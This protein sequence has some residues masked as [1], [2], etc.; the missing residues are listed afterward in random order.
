MRGLVVAA[1]GA[2]VL[3]GCRIDDV[4]Y[5]NPDGDG[6][7]DAVDAVD[8]I[9]ATPGTGTILAAPTDLT[10]QEGSATAAG[11]R[12]SM[13][14]SAAVTVSV[15]AGG[16]ASGLAFTP[17]SLEFTPANWS[18]EQ[19]IFIDAVED[20][21]ASDSRKVI[22]FS[23]P[24][25]AAAMVPISITDNDVLALFV[26]PPA[27]DVTEGRTGMLQI[28]LTAAPA[29]MTTVTLSSSAPGVATVAPPS[30]TFT[31]ANWS[32][33]QSATVTGVDDPD[34]AS[35]TAVV[36]VAAPGMNSA[37][38]TV[39]VADDDVLAIVPST[40]TL[41][42]R[43]G[44]TSMGFSVALTQPPP[45]PMTVQ[46]TSSDPAVT[47]S[48]STLTFTTATAQP[49][50]INGVP[51]PDYADEAV[52]VTLRGSLPNVEDRLVAVAVTDVDIPA[53]V[54]SATSL[55]ATERGAPVTLDVHLAYQPVASAVVVLATLGSTRISLDRTQLTFTAGNY[56]T[57]QRVTITPLT[58]NDLAINNVAITLS[59]P[60]APSNVGV[61]VSIADADRQ[62][63]VATPTSLNVDEGAQ[64]TFTVNLGFVPSGSVSVAVAAGDS[65]LQ[66]MPSS[67]PFDATTWS[68]PRTVTVTASTDV[69]T[70]DLL[71]MATLSGAAAPQPTVVP[72]RIID[73]SVT[74]LA[75][76]P[77]MRTVAEGGTTTFV[78]T[79]T[80]QPSAPINGTVM[81]SDATIATV[82]RSTFVLDGANWNTGITVVVTGVPDANITDDT[83]TITFATG[84]A[85][86]STTVHVIDDDVLQVVL[87]TTDVRVP[88]T[89]SATVNVT[90]SAAPVANT[91]VTVAAPAGI[92]ASTASLAF[93]ATDWNSPHPVV[94]TAERDDDVI[95]DAKVVTFTPS[96]TGVA[97][98]A[99]VT[100]TVDFTIITGFPVPVADARARAVPSLHAW[101]APNVDHDGPVALPA[102]V[103][104]DK[105]YAVSEVTSTE[106]VQVGLYTPDG[107]GEPNVRV[108]DSASRVLAPGLNTYTFI[109]LELCARAPA[110][111]LAVR[112]SANAMLGHQ[113]LGA[114]IAHCTRN[115]GGGGIPTSFQGGNISCN[116]DAQPVAVW[117][118]VHAKTACNCTP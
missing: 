81:T 85:T 113:Q 73:R 48:P 51:D 97:A 102:C 69:D 12:L 47:V 109:G 18:A 110:V 77:S 21:D 24:G 60:D 82:N 74:E 57:D 86:R 75:V 49:V 35:G 88:E 105:M 37:E 79:L 72:V 32:T 8:A 89:G 5:L 6:G 62:T 87:S 64:T 111:F 10:V 13:P 56:A 17:S 59:T 116:T 14:P 42:I 29:T 20:D 107:N 71:T 106:T 22:V 43:E 34:I 38:V 90:L 76:S 78:V 45:S 93:N 67:L 1:I 46:L 92:M 99:T 58:D 100:E 94:L 104:I 115:G 95:L 41:T 9:D 31:S 70:L 114:P 23:A 55:S 3:V 11:V 26:T 118:V 83:A 117:F 96:P 101:L 63:L 84:A 25:Y 40:T 54:V 66:L 50:T 33:V 2:L 52:T 15:S 30:L 61:T 36:T 19:A 108:L 44:G 65:R 112:T 80:A 103:E 98:S 53:I 4:R 27:L 39:A 68:T 91:T 16:A 7:A 28:S